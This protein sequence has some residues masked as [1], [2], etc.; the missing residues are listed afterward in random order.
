MHT[1]KNHRH[2]LNY[3]PLYKFLRSQVGQDWDSVYSEAVSRLPPNDDSSRD[4]IFD[5]VWRENDNTNQRL[6]RMSYMG[7][8]HSA[9]YVDQETNRLQLGKQPA[10]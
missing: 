3:S 1:K 8:Y 6:I 9:L 7:Y 10:C 4:R 2:G 5:V